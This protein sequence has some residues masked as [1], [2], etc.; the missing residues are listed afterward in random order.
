MQ[1]INHTEQKLTLQV[2][3]AH[4]AHELRRV[5]LFTPALCHVRQGRKTLQWGEHVEIAKAGSLI[6]FP[7]GAEMCMANMPDHRGYASDIVYIPQPVLARFKTRYPS[8]GVTG[9]AQL[10]VPLDEHTRHMW[11]GLLST[12]KENMPSPLQEHQVHG[13]LLALQLSGHTDWL[14]RDRHDPLSAQIQQLIMLEPAR[15]WQI[16]DVANRLHLGG[17]T[18]RRRLAAEGQH[19]RVLLED[20]RMN[21]A[22]YEL[23]SSEYNVGEIAFRNGYACASRFTA[24][25]TKHFGLSPRELRGT[26]R[27][28]GA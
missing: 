20:V 17:S 28:Q 25:F 21:K 15:N 11:G 19:F 1:Q 2:L 9:E 12:I 8:V 10:C 7:A 27:K 16:D 26:L 23:Q 13:V 6:L 14:M 4:R 3:M 24:R 18:L 5:R 22:L